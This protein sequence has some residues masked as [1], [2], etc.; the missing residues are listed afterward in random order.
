MM[1]SSQQD[2][3]MLDRY[4]GK[5]M[6]REES[7]ELEARFA[8]DPELKADLDDLLVLGQGLRVHDLQAKLE[9]LKEWEAGE[10]SPGKKSPGTGPVNWKLPLFIIFLAAVGFLVYKF[11]FSNTKNLGTDRAELYAT[12]FDSE[13]ILH[14]TKRAVSQADD[15]TQEQ[16]RAYELYSLQLFDEASPLLK[17]LWEHNSDTLALFY[18]GVS[19]MGLGHETSGLEVFA[20]PALKKYSD[21]I[22]LFNP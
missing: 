4:I 19:E 1:R 18:Y 11:A 13:L 21:K 20:N 2:I 9:M 10:K 7:L 17:N 5:K 16:R 22:R 3:D 14:T 12:R 15:L 6:S 8:N